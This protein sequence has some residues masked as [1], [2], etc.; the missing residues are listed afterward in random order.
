MQ[1]CKHKQHDSGKPLRSLYGT[2]QKFFQELLGLNS[3]SWHYIVQ[4]YGPLSYEVQLADDTWHVDNLRSHYT[5]DSQNSDNSS[6]ADENVPQEDLGSSFIQ[7]QRKRSQL[8]HLL[9][10]QNQHADMHENADHSCNHPLLQGSIPEHMYARWGGGGGGGG[11][12]GDVVKCETLNLLT[13]TRLP[14]MVMC[15]TPASVCTIKIVLL[16]CLQA[17]KLLQL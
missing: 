5:R 4:V 16:Q 7:S 14:I 13:C 11:G 3:Y 17:T 1:Q 15:C 12:G 6:T 10:H 2:T 8:L 9:Y